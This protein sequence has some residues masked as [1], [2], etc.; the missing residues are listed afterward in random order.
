MYLSPLLIDELGQLPAFAGDDNL[1]LTFSKGLDFRCLITRTVPDFHF[2]GETRVIGRWRFVEGER[3]DNI[4]DWALK[5]FRN[6][7]AVKGNARP[8]TKDAIFEYVY[9]ALHDPAYR[10][11]YVINLRREFPRIPLYKEFWA[12]ADCGKKLV[13]I[14]ADYDKSKEQPLKRIEFA[15]KNSRKAGLAPKVMLRAD[16]EAG[17]IDVDSETR[18]SGVPPEAWKYKLGSR[19]A[20]EW[21]LDQYKESIPRHPTLAAKFDSYKFSDYKEAVITLIKQLTRVSVNTMEL[22]ETMRHLKKF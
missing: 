11:K 19:S 8:I 2:L 3:V 21:V 4:T 14:H 1:F 5:L 9:A 22:L 13:C 7:Y 10:E 12:W 17:I 18:L 15:D 6:H 16:V 20:L